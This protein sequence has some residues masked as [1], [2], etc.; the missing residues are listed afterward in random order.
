MQPRET[1]Y[2]QSVSANVEEHDALIDGEEI[3]VS[4]IT[5]TTCILFML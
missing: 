4:S 2:E 1:K 5:D 3:N